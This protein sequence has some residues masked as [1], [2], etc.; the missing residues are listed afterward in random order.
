MGHLGK[1][2]LVSAPVQVEVNSH[3]LFPNILAVE[4]MERE[5]E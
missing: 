2:I 3:F 5:V 1:R 4:E